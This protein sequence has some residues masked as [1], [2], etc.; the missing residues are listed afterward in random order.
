VTA[1]EFQ[2]SFVEYR[3]VISASEAAWCIFEI[4]AM[5]GLTVAEA[6][7]KVTQGRRQRCDLIDLSGSSL[8]LSFFFNFRFFFT[9]KLV[10]RME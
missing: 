7:L 2:Q 8:L 5:E 6:T 9:T 1:N 10:V 4:L 3:Y